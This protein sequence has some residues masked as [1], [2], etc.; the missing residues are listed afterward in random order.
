MAT[1][2]ST[3]HGNTQ[4]ESEVN[5]TTEAHAGSHDGTYL[6]VF[7]ALAVLTLIE[8]L[9]TYAA[10]FKIPLLIVLTST[11]AILVIAFYMHLR[12]ER[13]YLPVIFAAPIIIGVLVALA[14]QQLVR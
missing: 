5:P 9:S 14:I 4:H 7:G 12:Y 1:M 3:E 11:K 6:L 8:V 10:S 13:R 2:Q